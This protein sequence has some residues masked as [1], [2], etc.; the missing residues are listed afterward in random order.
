M[1]EIT[2]QLA[3]FVAELDYEDIPVEVVDRA[4]LLVRDLI[5]IGVRARHE[6][7]STLAMMR[8]TE[9]L[10]ADGGSC[11]VFG[12][13]RWFSPAAAALMNGALGHSLDFDDTH[14]AASVHPSAV[15]VPAALAAAQLPGANGR[16]VIAAIIAGYEIICRLGQALGMRTCTPKGI[17]GKVH[18]KAAGDLGAPEPQ[19]IDN[20]PGLAS[21]NHM[22]GIEQTQHHTTNQPATQRRR[23]TRFN[24]RACSQAAPVG[25]PSH[26]GASD[27]GDEQ[28]TPHTQRRQKI[29]ADRLAL[30]IEGATQGQPGRL[31]GGA[32][33][34]PHNEGW[35]HH[36]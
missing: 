30:L 32:Y 25:E 13:S 1:M 4:K 11:G 36:P 2:R 3:K 22:N 20:A 6:A 16:E 35:Q 19:A 33:G 18:P 5:G 14:A 15:V 12:D 34:G 24:R 29:E 26:Q 10:G 8:A 9:I 28:C 23:Q 17:V 7:D 27:D 31:V 21:D